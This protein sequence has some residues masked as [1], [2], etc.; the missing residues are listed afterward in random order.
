MELVP[1]QLHPVKVFAL[2]VGHESMVLPTRKP[3][4]APEQ[5]LR[6]TREWPH[7]QSAGAKLKGTAGRA[8][9]LKN[10]VLRHLVLHCALPGEQSG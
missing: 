1:T 4:G 5:N 2:P 6:A 8:R 3:P 10:L 9:N 7:S